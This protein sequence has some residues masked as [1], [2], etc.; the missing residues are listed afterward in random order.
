MAACVCDAKHGRHSC[1]PHVCSYS[2]RRRRLHSC[3]QLIVNFSALILCYRSRLLCLHTDCC[4]SVRRHCSAL[5][6]RSIARKY[7]VSSLLDLCGTCRCNVIDVNCWFYTQVFVS[8]IDISVY[9]TWQ[10]SIHGIFHFSFRMFYICS[11]LRHYTHNGSVAVWNAS[12][13]QLFHSVCIYP[14]FYMHPVC[15]VVCGFEFF[16]SKQVMYMDGISQLLDEIYS[17]RSAPALSMRL[18]VTLWS[19]CMHI[20]WWLCVGFIQVL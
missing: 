16:I 14:V 15:H 3:Q 8:S 4:L 5:S 20:T 7:F 6:D 2:V 10:M 17:R 19:W 12:I 1:T 13:P 18:P 9:S 11:Y